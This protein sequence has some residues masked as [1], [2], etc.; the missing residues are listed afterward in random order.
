MSDQFADNE[1]EE[2]FSHATLPAYLAEWRQ[3]LEKRNDEIVGFM[4]SQQFE[5]QCKAAANSDSNAAREV[6]VQG[7]VLFPCIGVIISPDEKF[8]FAPALLVGSFQ[9]TIEALI[10]CSALSARLRRLYSPTAHPSDPIDV[11]LKAII[12][13]DS[14]E[15]M[16]RT[17]IPPEATGGI[18]VF[19]FSALIYREKKETEIFTILTRPGAERAPM[20]HIPD[21]VLYGG[22]MPSGVETFYKRQR[23]VRRSLEQFGV[24]LKWAVII[25][26]C[27]LLSRCFKPKDDGPPV[28]PKEK[29]KGI[30]EKAWEKTM[31]EREKRGQ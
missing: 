1:F 31:R 30:I 29:E 3:L 18:E 24:L 2:I 27:F 9:P 14:Y 11:K 20:L 10:E 28:P 6:S 17:L 12:D 22:P 26:I 8:K 13:D 21:A 4:T 19:A 16:K 25:G 23:Y 7:A 15:P 5:L